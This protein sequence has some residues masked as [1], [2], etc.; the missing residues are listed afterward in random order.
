MKGKL[1]KSLSKFMN[2]NIVERETQE[3]L[4]VAD[5]KLSK[6]FLDELGIAC[7]HNNQI[8]ELMRVIRF[9]IA[10]LLERSIYLT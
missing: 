6:V 9:N 7:K 2:K 1:P 10:S 8:N 5:K 4:A 3:I